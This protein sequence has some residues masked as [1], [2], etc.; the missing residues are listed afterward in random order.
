MVGSH[1]YLSS[2]SEPVTQHCTFAEVDSIG[3]R[4]WDW[5]TAEY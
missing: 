4:A 2:E 1:Y 5:K 3:V